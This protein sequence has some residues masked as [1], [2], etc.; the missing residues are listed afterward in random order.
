MDWVCFP[1][2]PPHQEFNLSLGIWGMAAFVHQEILLPPLHFSC[3]TKYFSS[4]VTLLPCHVLSSHVILKSWPGVMSVCVA[5]FVKY[6]NGDNN[7]SFTLMRTLKYCPLH[8]E[9]VL[10]YS[11]FL[12]NPECIL[13]NLQFC[14]KMWGIYGVREKIAFVLKFLNLHFSPVPEYSY[15]QHKSLECILIHRRTY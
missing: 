12:F 9:V 3:V 10:R 7:Y 6:S 13:L 2:T 14:M 1:T 15:L 4:P 11:I 8:R 5:S